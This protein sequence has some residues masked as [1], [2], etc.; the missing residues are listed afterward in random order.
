MNPDLEEARNRLRAIGLYA[1]TPEE[2]AA[3]LK[4]FYDRYHQQ[5][6]DRIDAVI[7]SIAAGPPPSELPDPTK[8]T[9]L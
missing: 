9:D 4:A 6:R 3:E 1:K 5:Q 2:H 7:A 8:E